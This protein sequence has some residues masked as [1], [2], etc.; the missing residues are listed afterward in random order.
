N[1]WIT[2]DPAVT[3]P[4]PNPVPIPSPAAPPLLIAPF[5][6]NLEPFKFATYPFQYQ[7]VAG[8]TWF[9]Y[10]ATEKTTGMY[11]QYHVVLYESGAIKIWYE[12]VAQAAT[13]GIGIQ[14]DGT[15]GLQP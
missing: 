14:K 7:R 6:R 13:V 11:V 3:T 9:L 8:G 5:W 15:V 1:G 4:L 10:S 12:I 2:L